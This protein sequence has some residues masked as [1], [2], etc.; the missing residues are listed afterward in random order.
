MASATL[1]GTVRLNTTAFQRGI[2][3]L[4]KSGRELSAA[5]VKPMADVAS[6]LKSVASYAGMVG[7]IIAGWGLKQA[8][9]MEGMVM[10]FEMLFRSTEKAKQHVKDMQDLS[11]VT[12]FDVGPFVEASRILQVMGG[13]TLSGKKFMTQMGDAA[14]MAQQDIKQVA[15]WVGR[16][17]ASLKSG[18]G[19]GEGGYMLAQKGIMR[20]EELARLQ[21]MVKD[22]SSFG[23]MWSIVETALSRANG[24]ME[25]FS[26]SGKGLWSTLKGLAGLGSAEMFKGFGDVTKDVMDKAISAMNKLRDNGS[27]RSWGRR[28][29]HDARQV[30]NW[31]WH[32]AAAWHNLNGNQRTQLGNI[33][34]YSAAFLVAW[35]VGLIGAM[36]KALVYATPIIL[37]NIGMI[38]GALAA[39]TLAIGGFTVG[40]SLGKYLDDKLDLSTSAA[41]LY[42]WMSV[43]GKVWLDGWKVMF[44]IGKVAW[45][46]VKKIF[47]GE[48][49][50]FADVFNEMFARGLDKVK[51]FKQYVE[52]AK[53]ANAELD[54]IAA[55]EQANNA[56]QP[57]KKFADYFTGDALKGNITDIT[58]KMLESFK[59][60]IPEGLTAM[61]EE[62]AKT[63][64]I[65]FPKMEGLKPLES[66]FKDALKD[67]DLLDK[68]TKK[69]PL[70]GFFADF[71]SRKA[72][73]A[74]DLTPAQE[75]ARNR[76]T[77]T[78][79]EE[80]AKRHRSFGTPAQEFAYRPP[81]RPAAAVAG[82]K[83]VRAGDTATKDLQQRQLQ[84]SA[85]Q[86]ALQEEMARNMRSGP[87]TAWG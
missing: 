54:K 78:P 37:G 1:T 64:D 28:I 67:V 61:L 24:S 55:T 72:K 79:A 56:G 6:N 33:L 41:K 80:Y 32:M 13:E 7:T 58:D 47:Q 27:F 12:P 60:I 87:L 35:R 77:G 21:Q 19:T 84:E 63:A 23:S 36:I 22:G 66:P 62:W 4:K 34:K 68:K 8:F 38:A 73:A 40:I 30:V 83:A 57:Q 14:A 20:P 25:R 42:N 18:S 65:K 15:E 81:P 86:T 45:E 26:K 39:L 50:T 3:S 10:S 48:D 29:A 85:K 44:E 76:R 74:K 59:G 2:N 75:Y 16:L 70:R 53:K 17:Y 51:N 43:L 49:V 9:D 69:L 11:A 31:I 5:V 71:N 82:A 52:E 46:A